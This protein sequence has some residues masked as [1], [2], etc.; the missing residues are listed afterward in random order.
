MTVLCFIPRKPNSQCTK[1]LL[2]DTIWKCDYSLRCNEKFLKLL[3][4]GEI[5]HV[6]IH[7][8]ILM[9]LRLDFYSLFKTIENMFIFS[10][11]KQTLSRD[12]ETVKRT[13]TMFINLILKLRI[14]RQRKASLQS[15]NFKTSLQLKTKWGSRDG[16]KG[17]RPLTLV[18]T[19][20]YLVSEL[21]K[22]F[23]ISQE[24][25]FLK[26]FFSTKTLA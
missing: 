7:T 15:K 25:R 14:Y 5:V 23:L 1:I 11:Q 12:K 16:F 20:M 21:K 3:T 17:Q 22:N 2:R 9:H 13:D 24:Y 6:Y 4:L 8:C 10:L 18:H 26:V 19:S